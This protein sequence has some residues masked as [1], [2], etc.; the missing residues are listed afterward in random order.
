MHLLKDTGVH[1]ENRRA[2]RLFFIFIWLMYAVVYMT[3]NCFSGAL[4]KIVEDGA[5]TLTESGIINSV[6]YFVYAPLQVVGGIFADKYSPE[7]LISVGLF[8]SAVSNLVIYFNQSFTVMLISWIF[9]AIIQFALWPSVFK[10]ISSQLVRSDR[11]KMVFF[12]SFA[13]SGGLVLAYLVAVFITRW[14]DN[15]LVSSISLTALAILLIVVC[16]RLDP[17]LKKDKVEEIN[18]ENVPHRTKTGTGRILISSGFLMMLI[19]M[20][21]CSMVE[22]SVKNYSATM[23]FQ[24]YENISPTIAN[25]LGVLIIIAGILG[26]LLIKFLLFPRIIKSEFLCYL[27]SIALSLPALIVL[28]YLG[29]TPLSMVLISLCLINMFITAGNIMSNYF[30]VRF[31]KYGMNGTAVGLVKS[32]AAF[33]FALQYCLFGVIADGNGGWQRVV[34]IWLGLVLAAVIAIIFGIKP[35]IKFSKSEE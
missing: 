6:F 1:F 24:S 3:K 27:L 25:L 11:T 34:F 26:I 15:F 33:G 9:N 17:L 20:F 31:S 28:Q 29:K 13:M 30:I 8:G 18:V 16:K 35:S 12:M 22:S 10:I 14:Q 23:I 21:F 5:L 7:K 32:A 4:A 19:A 2:S